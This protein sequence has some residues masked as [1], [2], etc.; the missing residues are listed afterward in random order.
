MR[1]VSDIDDQEVMIDSTIIRA[2]SCATGYKKGEQ[3][4]CGLGRTKEILR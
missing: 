1:K 4:A 2:H 3:A